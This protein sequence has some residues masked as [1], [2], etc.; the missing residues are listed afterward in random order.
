MFRV[1]AVRP[2]VRVALLLMLCLLVGGCQRSKITK[3]NYDKIKEGMTLSEVEA[4]LGKG[5]KEDVVS[6]GDIAMKAGVNVGSL[7]LDSH[8]NKKDPGEYYVWTKSDKLIRV[9]FVDGKMLRKM[10]EGIE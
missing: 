1:P 9:V 10:Q 6:K 5:D 2:L 3:A 4:I 8:A 7:G